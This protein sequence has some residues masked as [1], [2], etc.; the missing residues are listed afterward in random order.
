MASAGGST[1]R[2]FYWFV[3]LAIPLVGA[4]LFIEAPWNVDAAEFWR[5]KAMVIAGAIGF[6]AV[7]AL[8]F[9]FIGAWFGRLVGL[10]EWKAG[11]RRFP[12]S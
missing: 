1:M 5:R 7:A 4:L 2:F 12:P 8:V 6:S 10:A 11:Q 9:S 3:S